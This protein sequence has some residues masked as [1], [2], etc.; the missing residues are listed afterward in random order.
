MKKIFITLLLVLGLAAT[1]SPAPAGAALRHTVGTQTWITNKPSGYYIGTA[2]P[3]WTFDNHPQFSSAAGWHFG[4]TYGYVNTCGWIE[5]NTL[6]GSYY[7]VADSCSATTEAS[8]QHRLSIGKN[9]NCAAHACTDGS[10]VPLVPGCNTAEAYNWRGGALDS[11][12]TATAGYVLYRF[13]TTDG[14]AAVV[15]DPNNGWL[16]IPA[17]CIDYNYLRAHGGLWN[18]ND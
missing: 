9:F 4:R 6:P 18:D 16:F 14:S 12:G 15:R 11:A 1:V 13:T 5:P 3:G 8:L 7:S 17:G 2:F 10:Y